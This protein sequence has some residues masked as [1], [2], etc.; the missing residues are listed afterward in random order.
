[1]ADFEQIRKQ[2]ET[3]PDL[4]EEQRSSLLTEFS[5]SAP[6][7]A[8]S[9]EFLA[10]NAPNP[11]SF[12]DSQKLTNT[13]IEQDNTSLFDRISG[14]YKEKQPQLIK[15]TQSDLKITPSIQP[16]ILS[17]SIPNK[18]K[19]DTELLEAQKAKGLTELINRLGKSSEL[20]GSAFS[21]TKPVAQEAFDENIKAAGAGVENLLQKRKESSEQ[22]KRFTEKD[23]AD[24]NSEISKL[25]REMAKKALNRDFGSDVSALQLKVAGIDVDKMLNVYNMSEDRKLRASELKDRRLSDKETQYTAKFNEQLNKLD[26]EKQE[27]IKLIDSAYALSQDATK[28]PQS[29]ISL[30]KALTRAVEGPGARVSDKDVTNALRAGGV[31]NEIV[32]WV[33]G[34][35]SG[36]IPKFQSNDIQKMLSTMEKLQKEAYQRRENETVFRHSNMMKKF[37]KTEQQVR[38]ESFLPSDQIKEVSGVK[39]KKVPGGWEEVP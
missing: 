24:P 8:P 37:G 33:E 10:S 36:T 28:S 18:P 32:S 26:K 6:R 34:K 15:P 5:F 20:I 31:K 3:D 25:T 12:N 17:P 11:K 9:S 7:I 38:E 19:E 29:A 39:F 13:P 16:A 27:S 1:M 35:M 23:L 30:V 21:R 14:V 4:T 2:I 22:I